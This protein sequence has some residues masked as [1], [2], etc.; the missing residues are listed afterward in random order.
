MHCSRTRAKKKWIVEKII[1]AGYFFFFVKLASGLFVGCN[2]IR[3]YIYGRP[4]W[5]G[6]LRL[7]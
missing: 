7:V 1:A 3:G 6:E 2:G 5:L 4:S